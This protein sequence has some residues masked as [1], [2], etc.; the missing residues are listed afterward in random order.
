[1]LVNY[2]STTCDRDVVLSTEPTLYFHRKH[3]DFVYFVCAHHQSLG[4]KLFYDLMNVQ[5]K[6]G[7]SLF[8][9][10]ISSCWWFQITNAM[11]VTERTCCCT[12][13]VCLEPASA[14]GTPSRRSRPTNTLSSTSHLVSSTSSPSMLLTI[15]RVISW[16]LCL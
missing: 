8:A 12:R 11:C 3:T 14:T 1:M 5:T 6:R 13:E 7:R 4:F 2:G 10:Y 15:K 9:K 16:P